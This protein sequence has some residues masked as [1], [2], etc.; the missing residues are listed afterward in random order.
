MVKTV[1]IQNFR[2][3]KSCKI[4]GIS[5]INIFVG[6]FSSGKSTILEAIYLFKML[7]RGY[8]VIQETFQRRTNRAIDIRHFF[9]QAND[10]IP[11]TLLLANDKTLTLIISKMPDG[12]Y[13]FRIL[14]EKEGYSSSAWSLTTTSDFSSVGGGGVQDRPELKDITM[15][16]DQYVR[17]F[18][19]QVTAYLNLFKEQ[20]KEEKFIQIIHK[21]FSDVADY[22]FL[23]YSRSGDFRPSFA[24][25]DAR[26]FGDELSDGIRYGVALLA[27]VYA[28]KETILLIEEP[29]THQ[30]PKAL[31]K[32][33]E[34]LLEIALNNNVQLFITTHR[35]EVLSEI[36]KTGKEKASIFHVER[37]D[38]GLVNCRKSEWND[39][40]IFQDIGWDVGNFARGYEKLLVVDGLIDKVVLEEAIKKEKGADPQDLWMSII[41][42]RGKS[43]LKEITK[44]LLPLNKQ[45]YI[46]PDLDTELPENRKKCVIDS[47]K[48]LSHESYSIKEENDRIFIEKG[49]IKT[50]FPVSNIIPLGNPA[51]K[52]NGSVFNFHTVDDY[53]LEILMTNE[54]VISNFELD[55]KQIKTLATSNQSAKAILYHLMPYS[56]EMAS[57]I[58]QMGKVPNSLKDVVNMICK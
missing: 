51:L 3:I 36:I 11:I 2:G 31:N 1:L 42:A 34:A 48:S 27:T 56:E 46:L 38:E 23:N 53:I 30:Y 16:D 45:I 47:I 39:L 55:L 54:E 24:L 33:L 13:N 14:E 28:L 52:I 44:A 20:K 18:G 8:S 35:P 7:S 57:K 40:K 5:E 15:I 22:E 19:S 12:Q 29:E 49:S 6:K 4:A 9:Y 58:I 32:I 43:N 41:P 50:I 21:V 37:S 17:N 25:P 10:D 26:I